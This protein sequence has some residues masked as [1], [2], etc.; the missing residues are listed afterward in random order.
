MKFYLE[1]C[2]L[3]TCILSLHNHRV[4]NLYKTFDAGKQVVL[5]QIK[6]LSKATLINY[7][8]FVDNAD[9]YENQSLKYYCQIH[10][11]ALHHIS[12]T[13]ITHHTDY[14]ISKI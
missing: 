7:D 1:I 3:S 10:S 11:I 14:I 8:F 6:T 2:C 13:P 5:H 9:R 4:S 12:S